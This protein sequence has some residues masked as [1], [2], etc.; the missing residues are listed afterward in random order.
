MSDNPKRKRD[1]SAANYA[2]RVRKWRRWAV[3]M[4]EHGWTVTEPPAGREE[5]R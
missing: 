5:G 1:T 4:R 2:R 3:E